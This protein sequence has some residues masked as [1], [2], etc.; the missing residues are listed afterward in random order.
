MSLV[1]AATLIGGL[2]GL[3]VRAGHTQAQP[4]PSSSSDQEPMLFSQ[5]STGWVETGALTRAGSLKC[6]RTS[7]SSSRGEP[8]EV[9][10]GLFTQVSV[11]GTSSCAV[12]FSREAVCWAGQVAPGARAGAGA[13]AAGDPAIGLVRRAPD[14]AD[15]EPAADR[16]A[17]ARLTLAGGLP[18]FRTGRE[19]P[20]TLTVYRCEVTSPAL[21]RAASRLRNAK[22]RPAEN[23]SASAPFASDSM[24]SQDIT[25]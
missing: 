2:F 17:R 9:P 4:E 22:A 20:S 11:A 5:V 7:G 14:H 15:D 8:S 10:D 6:W 16:A 24:D 3:W 13:G 19:Q 25:S 21:R 18:L 23:V 1:V 12:R